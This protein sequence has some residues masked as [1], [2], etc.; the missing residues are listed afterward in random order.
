MSR[1]EEVFFKI[2]DISKILSDILLIYP[3]VV[4]TGIGSDVEEYVKLK[5]IKPI[6]ERS[7]EFCM[8]VSD[9]TITFG[10]DGDIYLLDEKRRHRYKAFVQILSMGTH[11]DWVSYAAD[12]FVKQLLN[13]QYIFVSIQNVIKRGNPEISK[14]TGKVVKCGR[15]VHSVELVMSELLL[16]SFI[17]SLVS[18]LYDMGTCPHVTKLFGVYLCKPA[19]MNNDDTTDS[20]AVVKM[21]YLGYIHMEKSSISLNSILQNVEYENIFL[22]MT[23]FDFLQIIFQITHA[24]YQV[25]RNFGIV[26]YD[27][28]LDNILL[29]FTGFEGKSDTLNFP[30]NLKRVHYYDAKNS[31]KVHWWHYEMPFGEKGETKPFTMYVENSGFI[32]KIIDWGLATANISMGDKGGS[33]VFPIDPE[34]ASNPQL[35]FLEIAINKPATHNTLS[36]FYFIYNLM[37]ILWKI[38]NGLGSRMRNGG[39]SPPRSSTVR[40][41]AKIISE[42]LTKFVEDLIPGF[43]IDY[44]SKTQIVND[45]VSP[46]VLTTFKS[47]TVRYYLET[48]DIVGLRDVGMVTYDEAYSLR[49]I[50]DYLN[51]NNFNLGN[52][53]VFISRNGK[54]PEINKDDLLCNIPISTYS[55]FFTSYEFG[56]IAKKNPTHN[57]L[58]ELVQYNKYCLQNMIDGG[59]VGMAMCK[60]DKDKCKGII[61]DLFMW[62]PS[63]RARTPIFGNI[64]TPESDIYNPTT[65]GITHRILQ[66]Q[67]ERYFVRRFGRNINM[68][69]IQLVPRSFSTSEQTNFKIAGTDEYLNCLSIHLTYYSNNATSKCGTIFA[70]N[71]FNVAT[72]IFESRPN[73]IIFTS[74]QIIGRKLLENPLNREIADCAVENFPIG[75]Y[76]EKRNKEEIIENTWMPIPEVYRDMWGVLLIKDGKFALVTYNEFLQQHKTRDQLIFYQTYDRNNDR[77]RPPYTTVTKVIDTSAENKN[78]ERFY[79]Y[80]VSLGPILVWN[81][82]IQ[83][84]DRTI[85]KSNFNINTIDNPPLDPKKTSLRG[86]PIID[87]WHKWENAQSFSL[88]S[89]DDNPNGSVWTGPDEGYH[90]RESKVMTKQTAICKTFNNEILF[91]TVDGNSKTKMGLDRIQFAQLIRHFNVDRALMLDGD[92]HSNAVF[93]EQNNT[94]KILLNPD[95]V[96]KNSTLIYILP[97]MEETVI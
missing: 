84:T 46:P 13:Q 6:V 18:H 36:L 44:S 92:F 60:G 67:L 5:T 90:A 2:D 64:V 10:D 89:R 61:G 48:N 33:Y 72:K 68:F 37:G 21:P 83:F 30:N 97:G 75:Y 53:S 43:N 12:N 32:T 22:N 87:M 57:F 59:G 39:I 35:P 1:R 9:G 50:W 66:K 77:M 28:H 78:K 16:E 73:G 63:N 14:T 8:G 27:L 94:P 20:G 26:H 51:K 93:K 76:Y 40:K 85:E 7:N 3:H 41:H 91:I 15:T 34:I 31:E 25:K 82:I 17:H 38:E 23:V 79:D 65:G 80:A 42:Q 55:D 96:Q 95:E 88:D 29:T 58:K 49:K 56:D 74:N 86:K 45:T 24:L 52:R 11:G 54:T 47:K 19:G 81:G 62:N 71:P 70:E 4:A 69:Y